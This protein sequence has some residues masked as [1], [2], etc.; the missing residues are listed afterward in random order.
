[1]PSREVRVLYI[2]D[3]PALGRLVQK[4][5]GRRGYLVEH[6]A[7]A[8]DGLERLREGGIDVIALDH[9]L[10]TGTGLDVLASLGAMEAPPPVVYVTGSAETSVAVDALKAG[11]SDYVPK[12]VTEEFVELLGSAIEQAMQ[13]A[14][15][16]REKERAEREMRE[17]RERAEL[18]LGE[19]NHRVANSLALVAALV[20]MQAKAVTQP[21]AREALSETQARILAIAGIH[22]RLYT[23]DDV[24]VVE[25]ADYLGS[26]IEDLE[27]SMKTA[28]HGARVRLE[29]ADLRLATDKAVSIGV[30]LTELVT[31]AFKYAYPGRSDGEVR[32]RFARLDE[33][34]AELSVEDDGI[35]WSGEGEIKGTGL[36]SRIVSAMA[37]NLGGQVAYDKRAAGTR[38]RLAFEL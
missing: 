24:R 1:M 19:V 6:A 10:P 18:L 4:A 23:S 8:E 27:A 33:R 11:A 17:A 25:L 35:G 22:R 36:G 29:V 12:A 30:L 32:V 20:A 13:K 15:L 26:L 31:N 3:D 16:S 2:D 14:R 28:G 21:A 5:L 38:V 34:R 37:A 7:R 9:Y